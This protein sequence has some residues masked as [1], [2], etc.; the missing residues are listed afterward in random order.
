MMIVERVNVQE[1]LVF[2]STLSRNNECC[3]NSPLFNLAGVIFSELF[4][5]YFMS[6]EQATK[7]FEIE[8]DDLLF[9]HSRD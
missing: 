1:D 3:A 6:I 8:K 2:I 7:I 5:Y 4:M 9:K